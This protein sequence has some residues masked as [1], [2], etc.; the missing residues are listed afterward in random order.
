MCSGHNQKHFFIHRRGFYEANSSWDCSGRHKIY[1][2]KGFLNSAC[3]GYF[4]FMLRC[5]ELA[6]NHCKCHLLD[7]VSI[8]KTDTRDGWIYFAHHFMYFLSLF[9]NKSLLK[10]GFKVKTSNMSPRTPLPS[11]PTG[12]VKK[13]AQQSKAIRFTFIQIFTV[14]INKKWS[15]SQAGPPHPMPVCS[16]GKSCRLS[17]SWQS[18]KAVILLVI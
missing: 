11:T 14:N 9:L 3:H 5:P 13:K 8:I 16:I 2:R 10:S 12:L 7:S 1:H 17:S 15:D 6:P 18:V 4:I